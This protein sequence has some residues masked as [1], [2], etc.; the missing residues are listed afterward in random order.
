VL[1]AR[2]EAVMS[3][4]RVRAEGSITRDFRGIGVR[5]GQEVLEDSE[6]YLEE[7]LSVWCASDGKS[8]KGG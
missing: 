5:E 4:D 8:W 2:W 7:V 3:R 1:R 6:T